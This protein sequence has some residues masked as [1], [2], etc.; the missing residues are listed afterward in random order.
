MPGVYTDEA[1]AELEKRVGRLEKRYEREKQARA[2]AERLLEEKSREIYAINQKLHREARL[3]EATVINA[4]DA[5]II[6]KRCPDGEAEI[7]Y[8]NDSFTKMTGYLAHEVL[9]QKSNILFAADLNAEA[10][11]RMHSLLPQGKSFQGELYNRTKDGRQ[12]WV[13]ISIVPVLDEDGN[14]THYT[15]IERDITE[16]K[17]FENELKEEKEK[18]EYANIAKSEFLANM[19]HELRTPMNGIIGMTDFLG[20]TNLTQ[21][22]YEYI[23]VLGNSAKSLLLILN[24]ILDLSKIEAGGME[25]ESAPFSLRRAITETL[26]TFIPISNAK[27]VALVADI[28]RDLPRTVEG[29]EGRLV[30]V[31]RNL[32]G[33]ALKF[34]DH[35]QVHMVAKLDNEQLYISV[36]DTGIGIPEDQT[37]TIFDKFTQGNNTASR[38]YG[39]TGLGL[40][41]TKQLV[42]MMGGWIKVQ[43]KIGSGSTF[44]FQIPL[45][46]GSADNMME[47]FVPRAGGHKQQTHGGI[48]TRARILLAEDHPTNQF[49]MKRLMKKFGFE[50]VDYAE[51]GHEAVALFQKNKYDLIIMD[52]QMPEMDGYEA[53]TRIR[54]MQVEGPRIP[55]IALTANAMVGDR[56]KCLKAGMDDYISKPIDVVKFTHLVSHWLPS[57]VEAVTPDPPKKDAPDPVAQKE[58]EHTIDFAHL[59][60]FTDGD[61]AVEQELFVL[62]FEESYLALNRL[63]KACNNH[64]DN[65]WRSAAHKFKGASGNL[66]AQ[67]LFALCA[68]AE[69][70]FTASK[71]QKHKYLTAI[72][73]EHE[74]VQRQL[75]QRM[76]S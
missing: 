18:A 73:I 40:A 52:C 47:R 66:G 24:D 61:R 60:S 67:K 19:S 9:G 23:E 30:Q 48:N 43:S 28:A 53:T 42:E 56:E 72:H 68:E 26:E 74:N 17:S 3:L 49:L 15:A 32:L 1:I 35:G 62:F 36:S 16:R 10:I 51:N 6:T 50:N 63:E 21:E 39:G 4:K 22:Q 27:G 2:E 13:D 76:K 25:L 46:I 33:N 29:D 54:G 11:D 70:G 71:E 20:G 57:T 59:E 41:I 45:T 31:L 64:D 7:V 34:T 5:V 58:D 44:Y 14:I 55:V 75:E 38:K 12:Y 69:F 65:E 8:V 37:C